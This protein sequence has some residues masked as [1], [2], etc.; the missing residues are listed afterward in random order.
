MSKKI[1][2]IGFGYIGKVLSAFF[3][4]KKYEIIAIETSNK[5]IDEY[6]KKII[7][8]EENE[9]SDILKNKLSKIQLSDPKKNFRLS[10]QIFI[11]V[12]TPLINNKPSMSYILDAADYICKNSPKNA[13]V[14]LK[15]TVIPGTTDKLSK[16]LIKKNRPD[17]NLIFSPE[18]LAEGTAFKDFKKNPLIISSNNKNKLNKIRNFWKNKKIKTILFNDYKSAEICKLASNMWIDLNIALGNEI[19]IYCN[20]YNLDSKKIIDATNTLK[21]GKSNINILSPSIG[22]GGYCLTKDPLFLKDDAAKHNVK[23]YLPEISRKI[24]NDITI[25][26]VSRIFKE[27]KKLKINKKPKVLLFGLSFKNNTG[28]CRNTPVL[29]IINYLQ[30]S[31]LNFDAYDPLVS[32]EDFYN[33]TNKNERVKFSELDLKSYDIYIFSCGHDEFRK[34]NFLKFTQKKILFD[35]R[36]LFD[37]HDVITFKKKNINYLTI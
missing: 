37:D 32:D 30:N 18:R 1:S 13:F 3:I 24:N 23:L 9:V 10:S 2:I 12:G 36:R 8:I 26:C 27:Y 6:K 21:K 4:E 5:I 17:I 16:Y 20:A 35:G 11:T 7:Q 25:K 15:S 19:G 28:D 29:R 22:V 14:T 33:L 31:K 34:I